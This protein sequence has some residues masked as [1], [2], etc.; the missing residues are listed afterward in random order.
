MDMKAHWES[1]YSSKAP[2]DV[3]WYQ[4]EP[5]L[6]LDLITRSG[7]TPAAQVID[8][9]GGASTLVDAL[10]ARHFQNITVLD[11]SS[12]AIQHA[13][14]RL[15]AMADRVTWM[16]A[17]ITNVLLQPAYYELWH[18]RAVFHFL[19]NPK[20]RTRYIQAVQRA[21]RP[22]GHVIVAT[23]ALDGPTRCSGLE[24]DRYSPDS[25]HAT[26]GPDFQLIESCNETHQTPANAE[27]RFVYCY[28]RRL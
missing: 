18:D 2:T 13:R 26:F 6:S 14:S 20:D 3:S 15:G 22:G 4:S 7:V 11:I 16:E 25:L 23:F 12:A 27:Q 19:T 24:V 28:C 1:I 21:V 17:D 8:V 9:G 10:L 5:H